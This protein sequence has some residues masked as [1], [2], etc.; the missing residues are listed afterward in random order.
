MTVPPP[1]DYGTTFKD[2]ELVVLQLLEEI[3]Q[4]IRPS[5]SNAVASAARMRA[6]AR[7][8]LDTRDTFEVIESHVEALPPDRPKFLR[9]LSKR[10]SVTDASP[11]D[12]VVKV[13]PSA[14]NAAATC[15]AQP[16]SPTE[17]KVTSPRLSLVVDQ[18]LSSDGPVAAST[19][20]VDPANDALLDRIQD[21]F[22][23]LGSQLSRP[24]LD[25]LRH[26][27]LSMQTVLHYVRFLPP[28]SQWTAYL[29]KREEEVR[30]A[31]RPTT[32]VNDLPIR[33]LKENAEFVK[34]QI[35]KDV[36]TVCLFAPDGTLSTI[37]GDDINTDNEAV[38][39]KFEA[40]ITG[41]YCSFLKSIIDAKMDQLLSL[42]DQ[43]QQDMAIMAGGSPAV[44]EPPQ[45]QLYTRPRKFRSKIPIFPHL[46]TAIDDRSPMLPPGPGGQPGRILVADL[47]HVGIWWQ[48]SIL[49][50]TDRD[51]TTTH[52]DD[53][54]GI[55]GRIESL[56]GRMFVP[57][58][59]DTSQDFLR[60][61]ARGGFAKWLNHRVLVNNG[62]DSIWVEVT[63][64]EVEDR[65][66]KLQ[67]KRSIQS[68]AEVEGWS[69]LLA[70]N[71]WLQLKDLRICLVPSSPGF[72]IQMG[73]KF[74]VMLDIMQSVV[75]E[76]SSIFPNNVLE[77]KVGKALWQSV[78]SSIARG[79]HIYARY[80][81]SVLNQDLQPKTNPPLPS[82]TSSII[83]DRSPS[84]AMSTP[85]MRNLAAALEHSALNQSIHGSIS[86]PPPSSR[87]SM[88][89]PRLSLTSTMGSMA[90]PVEAAYFNDKGIY[91]HQLYIT[92]PPLRALVTQPKIS[93]FEKLAHHLLEEKEMIG[94][95]IQANT[96]ALS[97]A[98]A[99]VLQEKLTK[100]VRSLQIRL[101][102]E[103]TNS[104]ETVL[105]EYAH[106]CR[107]LYTWR[108]CRHELDTSARQRRAKRDT[109]NI[110]SEWVDRSFDRM[111]SLVGVMMQMQVQ[112]V[113]RVFFHE[114]SS[115]ILPGIHE[116]DWTSN[117]PWFS[118][119]KC[120]HSVQFLIYRIRVV[121]EGTVLNVLSQYERALGVHEKM[122]ELSVWLV[123]DAFACVLAA[124]EHLCVSRARL[125]QW[126]MD[127]IYLICGVHA[128]LRL[129]DKMIAPKAPQ[130]E[131]R[132][133]KR[134][135][136]EL[137]EI[138]L[139]LLTCLA[140]R[141]GPASEVVQEIRQKVAM[142]D[143]GLP[144]VDAITE[145]EAHVSTL[146]A[147]IGF[148]RLGSSTL[149]LD[150]D[151]R[152]IWSMHHLF[153]GVEGKQLADVRLNWG[154]L[155]AR[156]SLSLEEML[157]SLRFRHELGNWEYPPLTEDECAA[158]DQLQQCLQLVEEHLHSQ[159]PPPDEQE[160]NDENHSSETASTEPGHERTTPTPPPPEASE[161]A[162][163]HEKVVQEAGPRA[164][165]E[166]E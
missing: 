89:Q 151:D 14:L 35:R 94:A 97:R 103:D 112:Y 19:E 48:K 41:V 12:S 29:E 38:A 117:K 23:H 144:R 44:I 165:P 4:L 20:S 105:T 46:V 115:Y 132:G 110:H 40:L 82:A 107:F 68:C 1:E 58:T 150:E 32:S 83:L 159:E 135:T 139:R 157:V 50:A 80:F 92:D 3:R 43:W 116:Q 143:N 8:Y 67:L 137:R 27:N 125:T 13:D 52:T 33:R 84:I 163:T 45:A 90:K 56:D 61:Y 166:Y 131:G 134:P 21:M 72:R 100:L 79:E 93:Q 142:G 106:A 85:S 153:P 162:A 26:R 2:D 65:K 17:S 102:Q 152:L 22:R 76:I 87:P 36:N 160:S 62:K 88:S 147:S 95:C 136:T 109:S 154:S 155:I 6:A 28:D 59:L 128:T 161:E 51:I 37:F 24:I 9:K 57:L 31:Y 49:A 7:L 104:L 75:I 126:K 96:I 18:V 156:S 11:R 55:S 39:E 123:L 111:E 141:T 114:C 120:T 146:Q 25:E 81:R 70:T 148:R 124:Y 127:V 63:V 91:N 54:R 69:K 47:Y 10:R 5:R 86:G 60:R 99:Q 130:S 164:L 119:S 140:I 149:P 138:S 118:N 113:Q 74:R 122:Q 145:L 77:Q 78:E 101:E 108:I 42:S 158:R 64:T 73:H 15:V 34:E 71:E 53:V 30:Q 16:P 129:L 121:F 98:F 66:C 133:H